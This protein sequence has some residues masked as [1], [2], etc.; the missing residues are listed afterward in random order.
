MPEEGIT[1]ISWATVMHM[2]TELYL[3]KCIT[4]VNM[5]L[6]ITEIF[7]DSPQIMMIFTHFSSM[8]SAFSFLVFTCDS[9]IF[10]VYIQNGAK[11]LDFILCRVQH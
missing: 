3:Q 4:V 9:S 10:H 8:Y 7:L 11:S 2:V 5:L 6:W 1:H